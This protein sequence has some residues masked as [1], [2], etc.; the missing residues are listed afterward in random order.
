MVAV[1]AHALAVIRRDVFGG[2]S[3][4]EFVA[5]AALF[6]DAPEIFTG[7]LPSPIKYLNPEIMT[8]Y[9]DVEARA[10]QK[11]LEM[12]PVEMRRAYI[13]LLQEEDGDVRDLI[14][15]ADK[16]SAYVK[17]VEEIKSGNTEFVSAREQLEN[18]LVS[19]NMPE[20][21]YFMKNFIPAFGMNLDDISLT[22]E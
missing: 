8:A 11:L 10:A 9:K 4:P 12:L 2:K 5:A 18:T 21:D 7:D 19:L 13:P 22:A 14:K 3:D 17:C 1:F 20:V 6:H 16:L 15:A